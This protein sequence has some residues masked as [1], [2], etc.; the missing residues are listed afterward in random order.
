M[1]SDYEES[2]AITA[3]KQALEA[4]P[5]A[6]DTGAT[7]AGSFRNTQAQAL[8]SGGLYN[9]PANGYMSGYPAVGVIAAPRFQGRYYGGGARAGGGGGRHR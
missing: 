1:K 5:T 7:L 3:Q 8:N 2:Q 4:T 9:T 6:T